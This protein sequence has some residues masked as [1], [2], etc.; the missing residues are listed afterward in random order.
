MTAPLLLVFALIQAP[1]RHRRSSAGNTTIEPVLATGIKV[2]VVE[3]A[4]VETRDE[5]AA[6]TPVSTTPFVGVVPRMSP[7]GG[8]LPVRRQS[9][10]H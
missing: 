2:Q 5:P 8:R 3:D 6:A 4:G 9:I 1:N 7:C 10:R